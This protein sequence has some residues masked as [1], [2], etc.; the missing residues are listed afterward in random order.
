VRHL[1]VVWSDLLPRAVAADWCEFDADGSSWP[2]P[3]FPAPGGALNDYI[4]GWL[5]WFRNARFG[6]KPLGSEEFQRRIAALQDGYWSTKA[7]RHPQIVLGAEAGYDFVLHEDGVDV[8]LPTFG[9]GPRPSELANLLFLWL[10]RETGDP[11]LG[12]PGVRSDYIMSAAETASQLSSAPL[13]ALISFAKAKRCEHGLRELCNVRESIL[14]HLD[15]VFLPI[16]V[17]QK[18]EHRALFPHEDIEDPEGLTGAI[19]ERERRL[20]VFKHTPEI[21]EAFPRLGKQLDRIFAKWKRAAYGSDLEAQAEIW[22]EGRERLYKPLIPSEPC[23]PMTGEDLHCLVNVPRCWYMKGTVFRAVAAAHPRV[24]AEAWYEQFLADGSLPAAPDPIDYRARIESRLEST[25]S[26][27]MRFE[28]EDMS[29]RPAWFRTI[30]GMGDPGWGDVGEL[31]VSNLGLHFPK[32]APP[33][34]DANPFLREIVL[35]RAGN[36]VFT[37]SM[38]TV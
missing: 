13:K 25:F 4:D 20:E 12:M 33:G 29:S 6:G 28:E 9:P 23:T 36:P 2:R 19:A 15:P 37:D 34:A 17:L 16:E 18:G 38:L 1:S 11:V 22:R 7:D 31:T 24:V 27:Q 35:G 14:R 8:H 3:G 21:A 30:A 5:T 26:K 32:A 10:T